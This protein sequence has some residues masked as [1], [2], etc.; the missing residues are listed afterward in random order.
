MVRL[1]RKLP[2]MLD[3]I[4]GALQ[5][6]VTSI[7]P[8]A[9]AKTRVYSIE[10]TLDNPRDEVRPGMIGSSAIG[11]V[12]NPASRLA[13]PL[14]AVVRELSSRVRFCLDSARAQEGATRT[15]TTPIRGDV[16]VDVAG[17][18]Y[19]RSIHVI[20]NG[21]AHLA[22]WQRLTFAALGTAAGL[23]WS[24]RLSAHR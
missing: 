8:Q 21:H 6:V 7:S 20:Q 5:G 19:H 14:S 24:G 15:H 10:V 16:H 18:G 2:V 23:V 22:I 3:A 17:A 12:R 1:G 9:D 4:E 13:I 11:A